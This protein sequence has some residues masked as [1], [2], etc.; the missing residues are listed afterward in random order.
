MRLTLHDGE[1]VVARADSGVVRPRS[2]ETLFASIVGPEGNTVICRYGFE[3]LSAD[4]ERGWRAIQ[5]SEPMGFN[6]IGIIASIIGPLAAAGVAVF[7]ISSFSTDWV[8]VKDTAIDLALE[9]LKATGHTFER[10][11]I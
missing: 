10:N 2:D 3:P 7:V 1:Y 4:V 9:A 5:V 8:L 11:D 6:E